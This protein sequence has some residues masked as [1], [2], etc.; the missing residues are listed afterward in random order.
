MV[1]NKI[2]NI[3]DT[4][5][6]N[7]LSF[8]TIK[9]INGVRRNLLINGSLN[10][11]V[12]GWSQTVYHD[13]IWDSSYGGSALYTGV[14]ELGTMYQ[15]IL[16]LGKTYQI[17]LSIYN[18]GN[19]GQYGSVNVYAG[20]NVHAITATGSFTSSFTMSCTGS[21]LFGIQ[22]YWGLLGENPY[23]IYVNNVIV[24]QI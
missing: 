5:K 16:T 17:S 13:W 3:I 7:G 8:S 4:G 14:D 2:D 10:S 15:N 19:L 1:I 12:D 24:Y 20:T 11:T 18:I 6:V 9:S 23:N 21:N 22:G